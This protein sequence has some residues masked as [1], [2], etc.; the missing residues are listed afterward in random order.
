MAR[1]F[2]PAGLMLAALA[3]C[4]PAPREA[5]A[6]AAPALLQASG[7]GESY[8]WGTGFFVDRT[9][10]ILTAHHLVRN[11][12]RIEVVGNG[13]REIASLVAS[14]ATDDLSLLR[15]PDMFG[16]PLR[17]AP[18]EAPHGGALVA[19]LGYAALNGANRL[20]AANSIVIAGATPR[21]IALISD[22][23][24]GFSGSPVVAPDGFVVGVLESKVTQGRAL[25]AAGRVQEIRLAVSGAAA[26]EFLRAQNLA[27]DNDAPAR[28][29]SLFDRLSAAEVKVECHG[30]APQSALE[31]SQLP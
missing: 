6:T 26:R 8:Y 5:A 19:V 31:V 21:H 30:D 3:G 16:T 17:F 11:C 23:R 25:A 1:F 27:D 12:A 20:V 10:Q 4:A 18:S 29:A 15:I 24:P 14:S 9:G 22:A 28:F 13:R 2:W 7:S